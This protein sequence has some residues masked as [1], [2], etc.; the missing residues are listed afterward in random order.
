[1]ALGLI[2][3]NDAADALLASLRGRL[4]P[5]LAAA[6]LLA[7]AQAAP[8]STRVTTP[9]LA[10]LRHERSD[11]TAR[12]FAAIALSRLHGEAGRAALPLLRGRS[13]GS[14]REEAPASLPRK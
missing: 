9:A 3:G 10:I 11:A 1:L 14:C 5:D 2:G 4:C 12:A 6:A 13:E 7:A 8:E